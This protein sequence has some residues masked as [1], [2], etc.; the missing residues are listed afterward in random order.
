MAG[1]MGWCGGVL[2]DETRFHV[3]PGLLFQDVAG[4]PSSVKIP[5]HTLNIK[6]S[7]MQTSTA[8]LKE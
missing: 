8:P 6:L 3:L 2:V 4:Q 1:W 7:V 5:E